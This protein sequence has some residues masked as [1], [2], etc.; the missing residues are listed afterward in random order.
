MYVHIYIHLFKNTTIYLMALTLNWYFHLWY[1]QMIVYVIFINYKWFFLLHIHFIVLCRYSVVFT[2]WRFVAI[3]HWP[4]LSVPF[5][6][7]IYSFHVSV[8]QFGNSH[9]ISNVFLWLYI[10]DL[11]YCFYDLLK[12]QRMGSIS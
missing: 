1:L 9:N 10:N 5:F 11:W 3:L 2:I 6:N 7:S 4:S 8:S 12:A